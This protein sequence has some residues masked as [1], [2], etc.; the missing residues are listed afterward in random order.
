MS[1]TAFQKLEQELKE[2]TDIGK[3]IALLAWDKEVTMP[4]KGAQ[5]RAH[6][7]ETLSRIHHER[8]TA[9]ELGR[10]LE[11]ATAETAG[12]PYANLEVSMIREAQR[13]YDLATKLPTSL[14][15]EIARVS[16]LAHDAWVEARATHNYALFQPWLAQVLDL[17]IK[18]AEYFGYD[19]H[20]YDALL[21]VYEPGMKTAEVE[22]LFAD[23]RDELV[24]V[25]QAIAANSDAVDPSLLTGHFP[26][27]KQ[28]AFGELVAR[29]IGY[30][31]DAGRLDIAV[32]PFA[33]GFGR[34]DA[35]ITTRYDESDLTSALFGIMHESGHGMYEQGFDP[36]F[37]RTPLAE[38]ASLGFHE[39][40]SRL[41]EN[42]L[43]RSRPFWQHFFPELQAKFS[44]QL[45]AL[46]AETFYRTINHVR[47]S[48]IRVDADEVTYCMH[49]MLRFELEKGML[50]G[51]IS[52]DEL[53][54]AWNDRMEAYLGIRPKND[55]EGVLQDIHWSGGTIGYFPTYALGT[56]MSAQL[57]DAMLAD[58]PDFPQQVASGEFGTMKKW[59][60]EHVQ[61]WGT[62]YR[63]N[64]L[65]EN[66]TGSPIQIDAFMRYVRS[67]YGE[68]YG[69]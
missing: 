12:M 42:Q 10:L 20:I 11:K 63:P 43:G 24:P 9:D 50:T 27:K 28:K 8:M 44:K 14:V 64:E 68:I 52:L 4:P 47:P 31:F 66:A 48:M 23:L 15:G 51:D 60:G 36:A 5:A 22:R 58:H 34:G 17:N 30:D 37:D 57:Y 62:V 45:G 53:P 46:D 7:L 19:D 40:Q 21:D 69:F 61:R 41:W 29:A 56:L 59:M 13:Q 35:R 18:S 33:T 65:I 55:A 3:S 54:E 49:I 25:I 32:H 6:M 16:S 38:A 39:S 2:I 26:R 1:D 67:K